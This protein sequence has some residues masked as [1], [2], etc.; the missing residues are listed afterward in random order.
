MSL[1]NRLSLFFLTA[2]AVVLVGFSTTL[3]VLARW[4]L[5]S[6]VDFRLR[7]AM[8]TLI[9]STEVFPD[10]I[11]WEPH[12]RRI[13]VGD[14]SSPDQVRWVATGAD[15]RLV[16]CSL[17]LRQALPSSAPR[18]VLSGGWRVL[19]HR[20]EAGKF[21]GVSLTGVDEFLATDHPPG[22]PTDGPLVVPERAEDRESKGSELVLTV[23]ASDE[24]LRATLSRLGWS[25]AGV[26]VAIWLLAAVVGRWFCRR[27]LRPVMQ[28]ASSARAIRANPD[29]EAA[30]E[31]AATGDEFEDLG[32]AFNELLTSLKEAFE[33]QRR[34]TGD[35]SHQLRTPLAALRAS[36][37]VTLRQERSAAEYQRVLGGVLK[38]SDQLPQVIESL[39][40]LARSCGDPE[41]LNP[42]SL[43][44]NDWCREWLTGW[45]AH[46]RWDDITFRPLDREL[47][48]TTNPGLLAQLLDNVLDNACKYSPPGTP[49]TLTVAR[50]GGE[51]K[52]AVQDNGSGISADDL[53]H[54]FEP[55]YRSAA[56]RAQGKPGTGLGLALVARL[57]SI[58]GGRAEVTSRVSEGTRVVVTVPADQPREDDRQIAVPG[59]REQAVVLR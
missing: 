8:Q 20:V 27:A 25:M 9:A 18:P 51:A 44:L 6:Q 35:A 4:H 10:H 2:L 26:S 12:L 34:F 41:L 30:L 15:G 54:V 49:I 45:E 11:E 37:E 53:A 21:E 47:P 29:A 39:L 40:F 55:F 19:V 23:A 33:R 58:L 52:V 7:T 5:Q 48:V 57:A 24:P 31:V 56:A 46:A 28:M 22:F 1:T 43:D 36:V 3:F 50:T 38:R 32:R 42:V 17:N 16:D 59:E 14:D 13:T